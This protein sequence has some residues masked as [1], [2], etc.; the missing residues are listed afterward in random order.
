MKRKLLL[1]I[2]LIT[3]GIFIYAQEHESTILISNVDVWDGISDKAIQADV[4]I[5][6][7][8]ITKVE[9]GIKIPDNAIVIDGK[10]Q[11]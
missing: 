11:T 5:E 2:I 1:S 8:L 6:N 4:L 7:N 10:G 3:V 9:L